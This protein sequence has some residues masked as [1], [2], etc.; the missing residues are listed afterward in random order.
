MGAMRVT[1]VT[2]FLAAF[3]RLMDCHGIPHFDIFE[4]GSLSTINAKHHLLRFQRDRAFLNIYGG[5]YSPYLL[6]L[7]FEL[8]TYLTIGLY[9]LDECLVTISG[10]AVVFSI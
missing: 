9:V 4:Q 6:K 1:M 7:A 3:P 5:N 8:W 10:T 2:T